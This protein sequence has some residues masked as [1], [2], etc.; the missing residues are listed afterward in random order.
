M[1]FEDFSPA[2][3]LPDDYE[4]DVEGTKLP[5]YHLL[6]DGALCVDRSTSGIIHMFAGAASNTGAFRQL[7]IAKDAHDSEVFR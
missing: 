1:S 6:I 4:L 5:Y 3:S 2:A 7:S